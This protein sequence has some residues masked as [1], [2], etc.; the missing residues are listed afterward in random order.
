MPNYV[1]RHAVLT[2]EHLDN[3]LRSVLQFQGRQVAQATALTDNSTG[4]AGAV[5]LV[6]PVADEAASGTNLA[7]KATTESALG[8][9]RSALNTLFAKANTAA[10]KLGL[11]AVTYNG[12]GT[13]G[14]NTVA[15]VSKSV[16]GAA[17]GAQ[18]AE[19][20]GVVADLNTGFYILG[21]LVNRLCV[22]T[23]EAG[24]D[25][26]AVKGLEYA[27]TVAAIATATGTAASPGVTKAAADAALTTFANNVATVAVALNAVIDGPGSLDA[28]AV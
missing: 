2:G 3:V 25:M 18:A 11:A 16:T 7:D 21:S 17:T 13:N 12:G 28:V 26:S 19:F 14:G 10:G 1:T 22:A 8:S 5:A 27:N 9:V 20:N 6:G 24:V 4:V 23:G 15:A